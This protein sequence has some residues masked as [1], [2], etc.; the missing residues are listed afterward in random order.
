[1]ISIMM[2]FIKLKYVGVIANPIIINKPVV[3]ID[4]LIF[5]SDNSI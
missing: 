3:Y 1:M 4:G 2:V 5:L